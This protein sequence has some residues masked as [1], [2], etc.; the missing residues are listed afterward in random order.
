MNPSPLILVTPCVQASG[1]EMA[2]RSICLSYA[3]QRAILNAGGLP[4][5]LPCITSREMIVQAVSRADGVL[6]TGG[7]DMDSDLY[8]P[9]AGMRRPKK[10]SSPLN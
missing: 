6:L 8:A 5:A 2:D 4:L 10:I 7:G 3:Y 9:E 1:F